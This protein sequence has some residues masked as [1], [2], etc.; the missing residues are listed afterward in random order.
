[1]ILMSSSE[2]IADLSPDIPLRGFLHR[3]AHPSGDGLVLTHGAGSNCQSPLLIAMA[4][5]F[6]GAGFAV[7]RCDL[8]FRQNRSF[9]PPR[10]GDAV[11]DREGL[12]RAVG[13]IRELT[14]SRVFLGGHSYGGRQATMLCAEDPALAAGLLLFSYPLHPPRRPQ[15]L[16][17]QHFPKLQTRALFVHGTRD[18]FGTIEEIELALKQ[19]PAKTGL[20][21]LE[22]AGHDLGFKGKLRREGLAAEVLQ[23]FRDQF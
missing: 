4:E 19:I 11:R 16:R 18:P 23:L 10:P 5:A 12:K 9:G 20:L 3:P 21:R 22:G 2:F 6:A 15:Q 1:L 13:K 17:T 8:P 7:L 14:A